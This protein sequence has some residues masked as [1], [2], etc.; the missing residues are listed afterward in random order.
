MD[1]AERLSSMRPHPEL[2][3]ASGVMVSLGRVGVTALTRSAHIDSLIVSSN[4]S[5]LRAKGMERAGT[6]PSGSRIPRHHDHLA[7][8]RILRYVAD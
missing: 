5:T 7:V 8:A 4:A 2:S 3:R 6:R 1:V